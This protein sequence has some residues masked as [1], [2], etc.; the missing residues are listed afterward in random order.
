[1]T[2]EKD[3][4]RE[5]PHAKALVNLSSGT[6]SRKAQQFPAISFVHRPILNGNPFGEAHCTHASHA[7]TTKLTWATWTSSRF[8]CPTLLAAHSVHDLPRKNA[9]GRAK[10][11]LIT[12]DTTWPTVL[13]G[14]DV[15]FC[16]CLCMKSQREARQS[17][18]LNSVRDCLCTSPVNARRPARAWWSPV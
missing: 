17:R 7:K 13:S 14:A 15:Y 16:V 6:S 8:G 12:C 4:A 3:F 18:R 11:V 9:L 2:L 10:Q 5:G 1:M